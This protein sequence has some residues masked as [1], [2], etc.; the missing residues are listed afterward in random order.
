MSRGDVLKAKVFEDK[1][2]FLG[3][4]EAKKGF[5]VFETR[6]ILF[7]VLEAQS[8]FSSKIFLATHQLRFGKNC[9]LFGNMRRKITIG[10][11]PKRKVLSETIK[12]DLPLLMYYLELPKP[13]WCMLG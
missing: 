6:Q 4:V 1:E 10:Q 3:F 12:Q 8:Q 2:Q 13:S 11:M 7:L 5:Q 9:N